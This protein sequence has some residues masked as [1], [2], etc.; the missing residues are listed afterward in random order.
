MSSRR[1][2]PA[3]SAIDDVFA[4][5]AW[6]VCFERARGFAFHLVAIT[7]VVVWCVAEWPDS[8]SSSQRQFVLIAWAVVFSIALLVSFAERWAN[9]CFARRVGSARNSSIA[10]NPDSR[11]RDDAERTESLGAPLSSDRRL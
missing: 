3:R 6:C 8:L 2:E 5:H 11:I 1:S 9:A 10:A 7:G 4:I